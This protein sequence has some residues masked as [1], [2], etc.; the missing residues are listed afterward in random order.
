MS[1][2]TSIVSPSGGDRGPLNNFFRLTGDDI[3]ADKRQ[4]SGEAPGPPYKQ[5]NTNQSQDLPGY[6]TLY[7]VA[8]DHLL[9][10]FA[11][12]LDFM[13][14]HPPDPGKPGHTCLGPCIGISKKTVR[15]AFEDADFGKCFLDQYGNGQLLFWCG[16]REDECGAISFL[17][18][19]APVF[20]E[21][22]GLKKWKS[23]GDSENEMEDPTVKSLKD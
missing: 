6:R 16:A 7:F 18:S 9:G 2:R 13:R 21:E 17:D 19:L 14:A 15:D 10:R 20:F 8:N 11:K 5:S 3:A 12:P 1:I 4:R 23:P 22:L